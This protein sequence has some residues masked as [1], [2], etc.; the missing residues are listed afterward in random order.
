MW[1]KWRHKFAEGPGS[2]D[3]CDMGD[4]DVSRDQIEDLCVDLRAEYGWY[5]NYRGIEAYPVSTPPIDYL[6]KVVKEHKTSVR[7]LRSSIARLESLI[8]ELETPEHE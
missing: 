6:R 2:W 4:R 5:S 3:W 8:Q 7:N 1:L